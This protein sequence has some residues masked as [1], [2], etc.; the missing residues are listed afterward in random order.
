MKKENFFGYERYTFGSEELEVSVIT[1]GAIV[2]SIRYKGR[3]TVLRFDDAQGYLDTTFICTAVGRYANR[4]GGSR[5]EI[6]G[7]EYLLTANEG[8]NQLHGGPDSYDKRR[9]QAEVLADNSVRFFIDSPDGDNGFPGNL[10][11]GITYTVLDN[12]LR[13]DIDGV[14]DKDTHFAPTS[15]MYFSLDGG[16]ALDHELWINA[17]GWLE[18]DGE[19]IPTG[20]VMKAEGDFDFSAMRKVG[21][22]YDHCFALAGEHAC[23][24][25]AGGIKLELYTDFPAVQIYTASAM[26][27]PLGVNS[28]L[29]IEAEF[30]P[31]A[32][33]K[34][35]FPSTLLRAGEKFARYA[36][37]V[38]SEV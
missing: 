29:A 19:L 35:D 38:Y 28:G 34:P 6:N 10:T 2:N 27:E 5:F 32:P 31:D 13:M 21:K 9:W 15:H 18:V 30:Y 24:A 16:S 1:L 37:F 12:T 14:C 23:A 22:D 3:E 25:Q 26:G 36:E 11:M 20:R 4:I 7:V 8:K 17:S 33:N